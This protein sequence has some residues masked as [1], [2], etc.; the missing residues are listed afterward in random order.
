M[1]HINDIFSSALSALLD[2]SGEL[3]SYNDGSTVTELMAQVS[4]AHSTVS[5]GEGVAVSSTRTEI[6]IKVDD[7]PSAAASAVEKSDTSEIKAHRLTVRGDMWRA[8]SAMPDH[9]GG[10][11]LKLK[12]V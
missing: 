4:G 10:A 9:E 2:A 6:Y 1:T 11:T 7:L 3:I 5:G 8:F 12:K